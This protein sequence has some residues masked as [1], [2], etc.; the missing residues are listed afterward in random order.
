[1]LLEHF[2]EAHVVIIDNAGNPVFPRTDFDDFHL[3][4]VDTQPQFDP[5]SH[6][7]TSL[8]CSYPQLDPQPISVP[9][10]PRYRSELVSPVE[11]E[12]PTPSAYYPLHTFMDRENFV[13]EDPDIL[14]DFDAF[15]PES[16]NNLNSP[17]S[18]PPMALPP[19][20][21]VADTPYHHGDLSSYEHRH[22]GDYKSRILS[23]KPRP[24][25]RRREKAHKCPVGLFLLPTKGS[26]SHDIPLL[27]CRP[28][29]VQRY[30]VAIVATFLRKTDRSFQL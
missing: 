4:P 2:E 18:E 17:T 14:A 22:R 1:M 20:S 3:P 26:A 5:S 7:Y 29:G 23:T 24:Y 25:Q 6:P 13:I 30:I 28:L 12:S 16:D 27:F 8:V 21:F 9:N 15:T 11:V 10:Q 19:S